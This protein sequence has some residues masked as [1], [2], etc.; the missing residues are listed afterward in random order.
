MTRNEDR[1][2]CP[3]RIASPFA[4]QASV[5]TDHLYPISGLGRETEREGERERERERGREGER[6]GEDECV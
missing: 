1:T 4:R 5:R 6:G 3:R 2:K